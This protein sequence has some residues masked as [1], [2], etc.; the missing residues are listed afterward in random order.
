MSNLSTIDGNSCTCIA[1]RHTRG[2]ALRHTLRLLTTVCRPSPEALWAAIELQPC[3]VVSWIFEH[4]E[5]RSTMT[6]I[7]THALQANRPDIVGWVCQLDVDNEMREVQFT[8]MAAESGSTEA[9][10]CLR[11]R[12]FAWDH[13]VLWVSIVYGHWDTAQWALLNDC[14]L[15]EGPML[16]VLLLS[17]LR[18][19]IHV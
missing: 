13:R 16:R 3:D 15:G 18:D 8:V 12:G 10:R 9:L 7:L 4:M 6:D 11:G 2:R 17:L 1:V 19:I 14:P 5:P